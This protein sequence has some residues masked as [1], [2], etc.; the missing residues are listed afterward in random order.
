MA[1]DKQKIAQE[2]QKIF[3]SAVD[4]CMNGKLDGF[5]ALISKA[6]SQLKEFV[7]QVS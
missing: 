1:A 5:E 3:Q 6:T 4:I 2:T 7:P